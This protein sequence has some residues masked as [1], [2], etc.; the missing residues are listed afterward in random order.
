MNV[1]AFDDPLPQGADAAAI[2]GGKGAG[3]REMAVDMGLPVPPGFVITT[4]VCR[5]YRESGWPPGLNDEI[6]THLGRLAEKTGRAFGDPA[7]PLL[8]SVRSGAPVSMPGMMDTLLNVGMTPA[9]RD[10]LAEETG[11]PD[12]AADAWLR[13]NKMYAEIVLGVSRVE[14][15]EVAASDESTAGKLPAAERVIQRAAEAGAGIPQTP[16]DQLRGAVEAVFRSWDS[17]RARVFRER[18]GVSS[19]LGTAVTVQS[20]VFGNIDDHSGTGVAFT[21]DPA[22][23][24]SNPTGDYLVRAQGEDVVAGSHSVSSLDALKTQLPSVHAELLSTLDGLERHYRDMCDV[25]FTVS[26]GTLY[27]LQTRIGRRSPQ[28]A[29][30]IAVDMAND[31]DFPLPARTQ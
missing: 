28:A 26:A 27:I 11:N 24:D 6:E 30:R 25:E 31:P 14:L 3:L 18:E 16:I 4:D 7:A 29:A 17:D 15:A 10:R 9:I 21:R 13:F 5:A 22:T 12:F 1:L 19:D 2:L 23:G 8:V 20:M